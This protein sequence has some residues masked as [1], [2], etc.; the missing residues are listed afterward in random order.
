[1]V[2]V[3]RSADGWRAIV[4]NVIVVSDLCASHGHDG[5]NDVQVCG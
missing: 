2:W 4:R 5:T 1:M 3:S